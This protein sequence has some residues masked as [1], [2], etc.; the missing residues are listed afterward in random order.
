MFGTKPPFAGQIVGGDGES[1]SY[2]TSVNSFHI[3][4]F[5]YT[6]VN[7]QHTTWHLVGIQ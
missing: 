5:P 3:I 1:A 6:I 2:A 7:I 4:R